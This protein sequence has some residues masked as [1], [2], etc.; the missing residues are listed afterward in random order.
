MSQIQLR[1]MLETET[2]PTCHVRVSD[3]RWE[4]AYLEL[5]CP[6]KHVWKRTVDKARY[7]RSEPNLHTKG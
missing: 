2:C 4:I 5:R 6:N 3:A 1:K 7:N